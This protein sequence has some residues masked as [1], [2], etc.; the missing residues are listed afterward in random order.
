MWQFVLA[1]VLALYVGF[2]LLSH[3]RFWRFLASLHLSLAGQ[4]ATPEI[5]KQLL[6][7]RD[8]DAPRGNATAATSSEQAVTGSCGR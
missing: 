7:Q 8:P 4:I 1:M 3:L 6:D 5:R 2:S